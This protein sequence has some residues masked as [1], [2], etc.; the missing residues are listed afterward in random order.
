MDKV[1]VVMPVERWEAYVER[2]V[3]SA[4]A[5]GEIL[6]ELILVD[7]SGTHPNGPESLRIQALSS[8]IIILRNESSFAP[9]KSRNLGISKA[10]FPYI[11]VL[12]SDDEFLSGHL[13]R[14]VEYLKTSN[15]LLYVSGYINK[16]LDGEKTVVQPNIRFDSRELITDCRIGHSTAVYSSSLGVKYPE[17]GRRHDY[18][19]WL[20]LAA[21]RPK[22]EFVSTSAIGVVRHKRR[23]SLSSVSKARLFLKQFLVTLRYGDVPIVEAIILQKIFLIVRIRRKLCGF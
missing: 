10:R 7:N 23:G 22:I 19:L 17:I 14:A 11:A 1:S 5:Q 12:D 3:K 2:A 18:A 16:G 9:A 6:G 4:L 8:Q 15:S 20:T 13:F 21:R